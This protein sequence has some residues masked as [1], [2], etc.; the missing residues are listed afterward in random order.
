[1]NY[2]FRAWICSWIKSCPQDPLLVLK[3]SKQR[4]P[5]DETASHSGWGTLKVWQDIYPNRTK[6]LGVEQKPISIAVFCRQ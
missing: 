4:G 2:V 5:S 6:T 3:V 1:M